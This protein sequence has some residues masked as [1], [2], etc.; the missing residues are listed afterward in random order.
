VAQQVSTVPTNEKVEEN[1]LEIA[2]LLVFSGKV[3][4]KSLLN[5]G[6]I[7]AFV[8]STEGVKPAVLNLLQDNFP[9]IKIKITEIFDYISKEVVI[10]GISFLEGTIP[11]TRHKRWK[12]RLAG[13]KALFALILRS[14]CHC[15]FE[16]LIPEYKRLSH[17]NNQVSVIHLFVF[18]ILIH[19]LFTS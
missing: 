5:I 15:L 14:E 10:D 7:K 11:V 8:N 12:V 2:N 13:V 18:F 3:L 6:K 1:K 17:D 16:K 19:F 9:D 4:E